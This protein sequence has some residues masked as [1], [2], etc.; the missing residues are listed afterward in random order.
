MLP[1]KL[2]RMCAEVA[3]IPRR[4]GSSGLLAHEA[5]AR[6]ADERYC[7]REEDPHRVAQGD[8]LLVRPAVHGDAT[9]RRRG[10]I[11]GRVQRQRGELLALGLLDGL[12]LLRR[13]LTQSAHELL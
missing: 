9:E 8:R 12:R 1:P 7:L 6:G 5:L 13:E 11:D 10:E 2:L 3:P 4:L